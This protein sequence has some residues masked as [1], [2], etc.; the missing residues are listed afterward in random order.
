M[1]GLIKGLTNTITYVHEKC[2]V[3][4]ICDVIKFDIQRTMLPDIFL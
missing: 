4:H 2:G 3:T 1:T